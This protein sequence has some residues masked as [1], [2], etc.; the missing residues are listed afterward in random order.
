MQR[1]L[2]IVLS[3]MA[4]LVL[5]PAVIRRAPPLSV[6]VPLP[7]VPLVSSVPELI[8]VAVQPL[9]HVTETMPRGDISTTMFPVVPVIAPK[10]PAEL[11]GMA[12]WA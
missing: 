6:S 4:L 5:L 10:L 8:V 11:Y 2:D 9:L 7:I 3:V 12:P 1:L